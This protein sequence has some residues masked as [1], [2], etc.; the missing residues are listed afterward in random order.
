MS[1][2]DSWS[3]S[4]WALEQDGVG[5]WKSL[6]NHFIVQ[7][8]ALSCES[9]VICNWSKRS[10]DSCVGH[11]LG[12]LISIVKSQKKAGCLGLPTVFEYKSLLFYL[13]CNMS[14]IVFLLRFIIGRVT[15]CYRLCR[16]TLMSNGIRDMFTC[17]CASNIEWIALWISLVP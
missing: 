12:Y 2:K 8:I 7:K 14:K 1:L 6:S 17:S 16:M 4:V 9:D 13:C 5:Q 11:I 3:L 10:G 15:S